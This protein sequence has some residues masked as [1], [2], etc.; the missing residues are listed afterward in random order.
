MTVPIRLQL[1]AW[2]FLV[3][4]LTLSLFGVGMFVAMHLAIDQAVDRWLADTRT[5]VNIRFH[6]EALK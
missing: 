3:M 4:L 5:Q 1:T 2:Y 6:D